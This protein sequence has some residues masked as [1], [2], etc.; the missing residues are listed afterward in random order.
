MAE[1]LHD[2]PKVDIRLMHV[3]RADQTSHRAWHGKPIDAMTKDVRVATIPARHIHPWVIPVG[4]AWNRAI[5]R[6]R[7]IDGITAGQIDR[8]S[9]HY[10]QH[11]WLLSRRAVVFGDLPGS[12]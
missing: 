10:R 9:D 3:A 11:G 4:E 2:Q 8:G 7:R 6:D 5:P 1:L 12:I